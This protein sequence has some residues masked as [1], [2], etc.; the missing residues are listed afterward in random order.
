MNTSTRFRQIFWGLL[1]VILDLKLNGFDVLPDFIGYILVA[2]GCGG[3]ASLSRRFSTAQTLSG[4][5]VVLSLV[6]FVFP[7][8]LA[9][10]YGLVYLAVDCAMIWFLLGGVMEFASARERPDLERL[11]SSRRVAYVVLMSGITLIGLVAQG[12]QQ[13]TLLMLV[14]FVTCTIPLLILILHL[15]HRVQHELGAD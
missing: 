13:V 7:T 12:S 10:L 3:L 5:L 8:D 15:I 2:V 9:F 14:I 4:V 11:A 1:L 6:G